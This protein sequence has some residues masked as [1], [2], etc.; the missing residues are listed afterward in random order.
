MALTKW[1][2]RLCKRIKINADLK[3]KVPYPTE[4]T[5]SETSTKKTTTQNKLTGNK[6][7]ASSL[8]FIALVN[9]GRGK[10]EI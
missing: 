7:V 2:N 9:R 8:E 5:V 1:L 4:S 10:Y 3:F 6:F